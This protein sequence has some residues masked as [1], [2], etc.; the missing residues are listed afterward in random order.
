MERL[1]RDNFPLL[2]KKDTDA[3]GASAPAG[4][5][6]LEHPSQG[7]SQ[8]TSRTG[9]AAHQMKPLASDFSP[10]SD[11]V[12]CGRG[13]KCYN[14][15]GN[16]RFRRRVMTMLDEYSKAKSKLDKSGVLSRV[17]SDVRRASPGGGFVK[18]DDSGRWFEVGDFLAREKTSQAF[19]DALHER[20]KSS[21]ISKK[22]RRQ[23]EQAKGSDKAQRIAH[24]EKE[25][26]SRLE[27]I[28][29]DLMGPGKFD[30]QGRHRDVHLLFSNIHC[31]SFCRSH[32][33]VFTE[34]SQC[35][36]SSQH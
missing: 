18:Q 19:R 23:Q 36:Q 4:L 14:H 27:R 11:D 30:L 35:F 6:P 8:S 2:M 26:S 28:T 15:I 9:A 12:I 29:N 24:S 5:A 25:I 7:A 32:R 16:E 21:N 1:S 13:K 10:S 3:L 33:P 22:K 34:S 17:M 20:Y 31:F